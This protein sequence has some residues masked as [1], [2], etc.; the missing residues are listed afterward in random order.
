MQILVTNDDGI[1]ANGLMA[2]VNAALAR[3][4]KVLVSAPSTQQSAASHRITLHTPVTSHKVDL[5]PDVTAYAVDGTPADCVRVAKYFSDEKIDFCIS[6][7][8]NGENAG[9]AVY[10]SGTVSAAREGAMQGYP[11]MAVSIMPHADDAMRQNLANIAMDVVEKTAAM[12]FP[13][14]GVININAPA[15]PVEQLKPLTICRLNNS[16][17]TDGYEVRKTPYGDLYFWMEPG[18]AMQA[19]DE[20][21]DYDYLAKNH[22]TCTIL[23]RFDDENGKFAHILQ[24]NH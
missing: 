6:G 18:L 10:Y 19:P 11:A 3:G 2:L 5:A 12:T 15:V 16:Y 20:G 24:E 13:R 22:I 21:S 23:T 1:Y 7:I 8:N 14:L 9:C 4:H 17:Y